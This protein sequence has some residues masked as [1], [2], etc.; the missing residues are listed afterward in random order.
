MYGGTPSRNM[1]NLTDR[2]VLKTFDATRG[3]PIL[4]KADLGSRSY[5]QPVVAG[6]RVI[7]GT[8]NE[9]PRGAAAVARTGERAVNS[10]G[11]GSGRRRGGG[12]R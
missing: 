5:A 7:V 9:R 11:G 3:L 12:G 8:N 1:V 10:C 6:G 4:W 2:G